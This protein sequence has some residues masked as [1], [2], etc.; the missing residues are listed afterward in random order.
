[1]YNGTIETGDTKLKG[2]L[3]MTGLPNIKET[4]IDFTNGTINTNYSDLIGFAPTLKNVRGV[5]LDKL[6]QITYS[7]NF[8]GFINDFVTYGTLQTNYEIIAQ[9]QT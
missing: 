6:G 8:T 9:Y 4:F 2:N 3:V 5:R 1:L 7:G